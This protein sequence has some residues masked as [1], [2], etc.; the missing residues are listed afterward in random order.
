MLK[1]KII[2]HLIHISIRLLNL[3]CKIII[4]LSAAKDSRAI[5][6]FKYMLMCKVMSNNK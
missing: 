5:L 6:C 2:R 1:I 4:I 3:L